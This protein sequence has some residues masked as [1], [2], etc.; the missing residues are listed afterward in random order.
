MLIFASQTSGAL[1]RGAIR[2]MAAPGLDSEDDRQMTKN[3]QPH[4]WRSHEAR[5]L[6]TYRDADALAHA[7]A[8]ALRSPYDAN[9]VSRLGARGGWAA[10]AS[11]LHAVLS[12]AAKV[13]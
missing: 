7:I 8:M 13:A 1:R 2:A 3:W 10:S 6:P 11:A 9:E 4:S 5:Q 12:E